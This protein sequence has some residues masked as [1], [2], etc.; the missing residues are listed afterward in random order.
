MV[1]D[2]DGHVASSA[3]TAVTSAETSGVNDRTGDAHPMRASDAV[4]NANRDVSATRASASSR[5]A[6]GPSS[7]IVPAATFAAMALNPESTAYETW[8]FSVSAYPSVNRC[9]PGTA[10]AVRDADPTPSRYRAT[11]A[12][13]AIRM[14]MVPSSSSSGAESMNPAHYCRH[15]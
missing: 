1:T 8:A 3:A 14:E 5:V 6:L 12:S 4:S 15:A 11:C 2:A 10:V 13:E 9:A 7:V